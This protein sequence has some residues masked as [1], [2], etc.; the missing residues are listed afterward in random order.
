MPRKNKIQPCIFCGQAPC[1][2]G[3]K[4]EKKLVTKK[5]PKSNK[6]PVTPITDETS[7]WEPPKEEAVNRFKNIEEEKIKTEDDLIFEEA[8]RN[9]EPILTYK[10]KK[11]YEHILNPPIPAAVERKLIDW[12]ER[13]GKK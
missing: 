6:A 1:G 11:K 2:C 9:L 10:D 12:R 7:T 5:K 13:N 3:S 4:A 8:I